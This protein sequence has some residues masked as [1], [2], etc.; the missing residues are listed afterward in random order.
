MTPSTSSMTSTPSIPST[1]AALEQR[2]A[3]IEARLDLFPEHPTV[4][5]ADAGAIIRTVSN[6]YGV[7]PAKLL[8]PARDY[9]IAWPR[10]VAMFLIKSRTLLNYSKIGRLL[11]RDHATILWGIKTVQDRM[12]DPT[13]KAQIDYL[14][15]ITARGNP[16]RPQSDI[17]VPA[18]SHPQS[19]ISNFQSA[20]PH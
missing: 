19:A 2:L 9:E 15:A 4:A 8:S 14:L 20:I 16:S 3:A 6:Y 12:A 13:V 7:P 1:I 18:P 10:Q 5:E 11:H 17:P